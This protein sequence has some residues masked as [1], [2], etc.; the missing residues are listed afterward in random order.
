MVWNNGWIAYAGEKSVKSAPRLESTPV[1]GQVIPG[2]STMPQVWTPQE[3]VD[4]EQSQARFATAIAHHAGIAMTLTASGERVEATAADDPHYTILSRLLEKYGHPKSQEALNTM[5]KAEGLEA[6][7]RQTMQLLYEKKYT[8]LPSV[9]A[10]DGMTFPPTTQAKKKQDEQGM[11]FQPGVTMSKK[12]AID[13]MQAR[14]KVA[15]DIQATLAQVRAIS[16]GTSPTAAVRPPVRPPLEGQALVEA[17]TE[18]VLHRLPALQDLQQSTV[19]PTLTDDQQWV[20]QNLRT[21]I[22][23]MMRSVDSYIEQI[24]ANAHRMAPFMRHGA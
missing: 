6:V 10:V 13:D 18:L 12:K 20:V 8:P 24:D 16:A 3:N 11:T 14:A 19:W 22:V 21:Q 7:A 23:T 1:P 2:T 5:G 17:F 4:R 9:P 15:R